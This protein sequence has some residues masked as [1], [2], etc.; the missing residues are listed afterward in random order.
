MECLT[1]IF[2]LKVRN[3]KG[4][5]NTRFPFSPPSRS[6]CPPGQ[7]VALF[8]APRLQSLPLFHWAGT[9]ATP[10]SS[11]RPLPPPDRLSLV[12]LP[13]QG[14]PALGTAAAIFR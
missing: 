5:I 1:C 8:P 12:H 6:Q 13:F 3:G 14:L 4:A 7:P 2:A 11:V 9:W 10:L